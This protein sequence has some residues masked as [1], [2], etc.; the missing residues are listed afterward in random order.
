MVKI[1]DKD[2]G[3]G[4]A[5]PCKTII[6][7]EDPPPALPATGKQLADVIARLSPE[8]MC[9]VVGRLPSSAVQAWV[10]SVGSL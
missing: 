4:K 9:L 1:E 6:I 3:K 7:Q 10:Q 8:E 5:K 2:Q